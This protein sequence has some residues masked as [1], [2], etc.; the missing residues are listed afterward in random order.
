MNPPKVIQTTSPKRTSG[1]GTAAM[2]A[3][4]ALILLT[5]AGCATSGSARAIRS[6]Q[7]D[8]QITS[9]D[10]VKAQVIPAPGV[11]IADTE[12]A[13]FAS[14]VES[15]IRAQARPG[16]RGGR[17]YKVV[18]N[19]SRYEKGS[20]VARAMLAG[21]GQMHIDGTVSVR[22]PPAAAPCGNFTIS[23]TFAWGGMIGATTNIETVEQEF[24]KAVGEAVCAGDVLPQTE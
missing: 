22:T 4:S 24:A 12:R 11:A 23:K 21:L 15:A 5:F 7:P 20:A 14:Q 2:L 9:S 18:L 19:L 16:S 3:S 6:L 13:R 8:A 17:D 10:R 1:I